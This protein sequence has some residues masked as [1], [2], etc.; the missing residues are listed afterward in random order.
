MNICQ[1]HCK[2]LIAWHFVALVSR[3]YYS[4][5]KND[6]F[7][8][9]ASDI[10]SALHEVAFKVRPVKAA[11]SRC[12]SHQ[13]KTR[14]AKVENVCAKDWW[15]FLSGDDD[16][17]AR[18]IIDEL[19]DMTQKQAGNG[20]RTLPIARLSL[21]YHPDPGTTLASYKNAESPAFASCTV[22]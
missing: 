4:S 1:Q 12:P 8:A 3:L 10:L 19:A 6:G 13:R 5:K 11:G 18:N 7:D 2:S 9:E 20:D 16:Q 14:K 17:L 15:S 22:A 21:L